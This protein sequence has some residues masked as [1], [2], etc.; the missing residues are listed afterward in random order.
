MTQ[1]EP[2]GNTPAERLKNVD[3]P[4]A[5]SHINNNF[6]ALQSLNSGPN[7]PVT[8]EAYMLWLKTVSN[9]PDILNIRNAENNAWIEIGSLDGNAYQTKGIT[10]IEN[11]GTGAITAALAAAAL[12]PAQSGQ[13]GKA[14]TTD[15]S[16]LSW[17]NLIASSHTPFAY[18]GSSQ[19]WNKPDSGTFVIVIAWGGGGGGSY[20]F[21]GNAGGGG[22]ACALYIT[23]FSSLSN[24]SYTVTV[25]AG[26]AGA[27]SNNS[28][29]V[30]GGNSSFG[31]LVT[32]HGG[33]GA[34]WN[35]PGNDRAGEG[36]GFGGTGVNYLGGIPG[37][38]GGS[39]GTFTAPGGAAVFGGGGGGGIGGN[40]V[41][42]GGG[43]A[44]GAYHSPNPNYAAGTSMMG[45]NGGTAGPS[46]GTDGS[47]PGG[48]G[49]G[50]QEG[51]AGDG[52]AGRVDVYVV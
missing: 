29:G 7:T 52:G 1:F 41:Y 3:F 40:S 47:V 21:A 19:T 32:A 50:G 20:R 34:K 44:G 9:G 16:V 10:P 27:T 6:Q 11:G 14:L 26:G 23:P 4:T 38:Y 35:N 48:G 8:T 13:T 28:S 51:A 31:N 17:G 36:G 24:S 45:G 30:S 37:V 25:G 43:G 18:T 33:Q 15:G 46:G 12:L 2:A 42:G 49:G 5:R 39:Q 22:G